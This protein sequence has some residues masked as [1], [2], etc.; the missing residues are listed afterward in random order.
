MNYIMNYEMYDLYDKVLFH[1]E[2]NNFIV[3]SDIEVNDKNVC[4]LPF[5]A[6]SKLQLQQFDTISIENINYLEKIGFIKL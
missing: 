1:S 4:V 5:W 6:M 2:N 3:F